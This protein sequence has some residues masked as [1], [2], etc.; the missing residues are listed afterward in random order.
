MKKVKGMKIPS[1]TMKTRMKSSALFEGEHEVNDDDEPI[2]YL[3][4]MHKNEGASEDEYI[5]H[6]AMMYEESDLPELEEMITPHSIQGE[7]DWSCQYSAM[8]KGTVKNAISE[9]SM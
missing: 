6:C 5:V 7:W 3:G 8:H 4:V 2:A 1:R 9:Y